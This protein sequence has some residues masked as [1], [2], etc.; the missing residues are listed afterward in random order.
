MD[1]KQ[2]ST[3]TRSAVIA[4]AAVL[5]VW[6]ASPLAGQREPDWPQS[7]APLLFDS[8]RAY[9]VTQEFVTQFPRRIFGSIES[10]QST[11]YLDE[12]LAKLGYQITYT[13]FSARISRAK[14]DGRN[15]LGFKQG[16]TAE[17]IALIAHYDTAQTTVQGA[18][19]NGSGVGVLLEMAR[20]FSSGTT[21]RSLLFILSDG[22]EWGGLG[23]LDLATSYAERNRIAAVLSLD[24]VG[25]GDLAAF[26]LEETGQVKGFSPPWLRSIAR[27]AAQSQGLPVEAPF[28]YIERAFLIS[29]ADQGP[30]LYAGIPAINLGS[31]STDEA[32]ERAIFHSPQDTIEN[33]NI[34][35]IKKYGLAAERIVRTLDELPTVPR[36]SSDFFRLSGSLFLGPKAVSVLHILIL[37]PLLFVLFSEWRTHKDS[38]SLANIGRELLAFL[39]TAFPFLSLYFFI[40]LFRALRL[41]PLYNL[42]PATAK[43]PVL[44]NP[45]WGILGCILGAV[46]FVAIS[47]WL[48]AKFSL[49]NLPKPEFSVSKLVLLGL[50][51]ITTAFA[52]AY[53]SY[54]AALFLFLPAWLWGIVDRALRPGAR[55]L[56]WICIVAAGLPYYFTLWLLASR[57][58]LSWNF[59][60]YH[61]LALNTGLFTGAG[62][63]L[64]TATIVLGIRFLVIQLHGH[65]R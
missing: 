47:C 63:L 46:S 29:R 27:Q 6:L 7:Q 22:G 25:V 23:A 55:V 15:V 35:S 42:Y 11:G 58:D 19:K 37:L 4:I 17:I 43:D 60:W 64:G 45:S 62:Y 61:T 59:I 14:R 57:L 13:H 21:H 54:W 65:G 56:R 3:Q 36:E 34:S 18:M 31:K 5:F 48:V 50:M 38:L 44:E 24:H 1:S 32:L 49:R 52:L 20:L 12:Y 41:L 9:R 30:F 10:R 2:A 53:N 8:T 28:E 40:G 16:Q 33:L 39:G 51:L 26:Y